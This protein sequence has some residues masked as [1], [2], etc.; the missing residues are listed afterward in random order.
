MQSFQ[1]ETVPPRLSVIRNL[2][3]DGSPGK[4]KQLCLEHLPISRIKIFLPWLISSSQENGLYMELRRDA[5]W[6]TIILLPPYVYEISIAS[7]SYVIVKRNKI[8]Q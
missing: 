7:K 4:E 2:S 3:T 1:I 8:R 5:Q 6:H